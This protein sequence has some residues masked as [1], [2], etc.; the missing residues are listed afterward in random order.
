L[1][2]ECACVCVRNRGL[3]AVLTRFIQGN[4]GNGCMHR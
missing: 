2:V 4:R 3:Y 1:I